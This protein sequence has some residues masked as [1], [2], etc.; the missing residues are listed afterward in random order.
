MADVAVARRGGH[1]VH[2]GKTE[3]DMMVTGWES[4]TALQS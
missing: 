3:S 2:L 4:P 1:E